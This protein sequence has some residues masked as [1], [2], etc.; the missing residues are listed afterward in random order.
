MS[1]PTIK[2]VETPALARKS[3]MIIQPL[4]SLVPSQVI[5]VIEV[6][7]MLITQQVMSTTHNRGLYRDAN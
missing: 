1:S 2:V 3:N 6:C 5:F 7:C 4:K